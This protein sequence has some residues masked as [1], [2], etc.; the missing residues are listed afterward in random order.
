MS[1]FEGLIES[2]QNAE[3]ALIREFMTRGKEHPLDKMIN[4]I[5]DLSDED[6]EILTKCR[7]IDHESKTEF[8]IDLDLDEACTLFEEHRTSRKGWRANQFVEIMKRH[9]IGEEQPKTL[10]EKLLSR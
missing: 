4:Y 10:G 5:T 1:E 9:F 6:N 7:I 2:T 8:G 3:M